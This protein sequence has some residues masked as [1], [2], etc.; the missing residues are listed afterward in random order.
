MLNLFTE[1]Q[2]GHASKYN[3]YSSESVESRWH[4]RHPHRIGSIVAVAEKGVVFASDFPDFVRAAATEFNRS[5]E[6]LSNVYGWNGYDNQ[7]SEMHTA[8]IVNGPDFAVREK[9]LI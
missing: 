2:A 4:Y 7:I 6:E 3:V 8:L 1:L 9:R 5:M